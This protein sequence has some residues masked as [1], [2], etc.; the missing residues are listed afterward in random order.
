LVIAVEDLLDLIDTETSPFTIEVL[1]EDGLPVVAVLPEE[2]EKAIETIY[3]ILY[4]DRFDDTGTNN[5]TN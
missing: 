3:R 2:T 5:N 4:D 1:G